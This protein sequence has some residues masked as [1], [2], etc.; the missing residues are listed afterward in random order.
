MKYLGVVLVVLGLA[1]CAP[2]PTLEELEHEALLS[3]DWTAVERRERSMQR[4][5]AERR[6]TCGGGYIAV[7]RNEIG[8]SECLCVARDVYLDTFTSY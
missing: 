4:R 6:P 2:Y 5:A 3:G 8:R 7:C 1:A